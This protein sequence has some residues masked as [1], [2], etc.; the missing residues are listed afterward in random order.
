LLLP[1][2]NHL[3]YFLSA[4]NTLPPFCLPNQASS[5]RLLNFS[6]EVNKLLLRVMFGD[7]LSRLG[8]VSQDRHSTSDKDWE[9]KPQ[10]HFRSRSECRGSQTS[11]GSHSLHTGATT[12]SAT[13]KCELD[14]C[15]L[16]DALYHTSNDIFMKILLS[17]KVIDDEDLCEICYAKKKDVSFHPCRHQS[18]R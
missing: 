4:W 5:S 14:S 16:N 17:F 15:N 12:Q 1:A 13:S 7:D 2:F 6:S 8:T 10:F 3:Q 9:I 18:C 11:R